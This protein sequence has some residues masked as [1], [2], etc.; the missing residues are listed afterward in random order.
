MTRTPTT[1][2]E[3]EP[4]DIFYFANDK[5]KKTYE[6]AGWS[7]PYSNS[8]QVKWMREFIRKKS[9]FI[10]TG[11]GNMEVVKIEHETTIPQSA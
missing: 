3:L 1:L 6:C 8:P 4:G 11:K 2:G 10:L 9:T 7:K 5:D